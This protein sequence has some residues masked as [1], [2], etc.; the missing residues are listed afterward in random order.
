[1]T[2]K[3]EQ[4]LYSKKTKKCL[5]CHIIEFPVAAART[6]TASKPS[7]TASPAMPVVAK[8]AVP[9]R[10]LPNS[11]FDH[12]PHND[13]INKKGCVACHAGAEQSE[14]TSDVLLPSINS[15]RECHFDPEGARAECVEC[16][17]YHDKTFTRVSEH[18]LD[19][20]IFGLTPEEPKSATPTRRPT[21]GLR[22]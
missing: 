11:V 12:A 8:T 1:M 15:C 14:K 22:E 4:Y 17:V 16:H 13:L 6:S 19:L 10:W 5:L 21:Q 2:A 7:L 18:P 3:A 20:R 9:V